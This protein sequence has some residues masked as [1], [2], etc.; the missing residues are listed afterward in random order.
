MA[1]DYAFLEISQVILMLWSTPWV[2][3]PQD[4]SERA[5]ASMGKNIWIDSYN[6]NYGQSVSCDPFEPFISHPWTF[7]RRWNGSATWCFLPGHLPY[8]VFRENTWQRK[9]LEQGF[10]SMGIFL[11]L[12]NKKMNS[13]VVLGSLHNHSE[14]QFP[15]QSVGNMLTAPVLVVV[16]KVWPSCKMLTLWHIVST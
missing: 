6:G 15:H 4:S 11:V 10:L 8:Q 9:K 2:A 16:L 3:R 7:V 12:T 14:T 1:W 5:R 13:C